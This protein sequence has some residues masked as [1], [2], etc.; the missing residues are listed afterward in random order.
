MIPAG[1]KEQDFIY[2]PVPTQLV[3]EFYNDFC[4]LLNDFSNTV[5]ICSTIEVNAPAVVRICNRVDQRKDYYLYYHST[6]EKVMHMS[7]EKEMGLWAYWVC[8]YKPVRFLNKEEEE[9]FFLQNGCDVSDA[10][11]AYIIISIV[12]SNNNGRAKYFNSKR[13]ADLYYDL[14]NRDFSKEAI[15]SRIEDLIT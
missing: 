5:K 4:S 1:I 11:A 13:V 10:F 3:M 12:C 9:L 6:E 15:M 2:R 7:H 14:A 8:K